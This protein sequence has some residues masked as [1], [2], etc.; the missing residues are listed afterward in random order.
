MKL[1]L[2]KL[3]L[4][5]RISLLVIAGLLSIVGMYQVANA[6]QPVPVSKPTIKLQAGGTEPFWGMTV[7]TQG[8]EFQR[9]GEAIVKF[10]Y[11]KPLAAVGRPADVVQVYRLKNKSSSGVLVVNRS[12]CSDG[13]SDNQHPFTVTL[14][15]NNQVFSGCA[16]SPSHPVIQGNER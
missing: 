3:G 11:T 13:M 9:A 1:N 15:L 12:A 4:K 16:S 2:I 14:M 8:I 5:S 10:P 6:S 7:K